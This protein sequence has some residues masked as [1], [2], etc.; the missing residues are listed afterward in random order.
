M[1]TTTPMENLTVRL[2]GDLRARL[3]AEADRERR[4][5]SNLVR[6]VLT[7]WVEQRVASEQE[8]A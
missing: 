5:V 3:E 4:P 7:D 2:G 1:K 6:I 8:A